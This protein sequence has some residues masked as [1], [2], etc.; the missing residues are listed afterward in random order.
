M[1]V[2]RSFPGRIRFSAQNP[3]A[4]QHLQSEAETALAQIDTQV[5]IEYS[6]RTQ[7]GVLKFEKS[8]TITDML[9]DVI[10]SMSDKLADSCVTTKTECGLLQ[11]GRA[12][13]RE[14]V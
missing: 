11:I 14:R 5:Q 2:I 4:L 6:P 12:S 7:R 13:C 8:Q 9:V 10:N 1:A 3:A